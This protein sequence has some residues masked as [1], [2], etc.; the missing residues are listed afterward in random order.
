MPPTVE[1]SNIGL[2]IAIGAGALALLFAI[3]LA[4]RVMRVDEGNERV[5]EIGKAIQEG[6]SAFLSRE[7]RVLLIFVVIVTGVLLLLGFI[8]DEQDW[9]V[10]ISY[11][12]GAFGSGLT[13]LIG[14][15]VAVRAN[16]RTAAAATRALNPALRVAFSS[17][18]VM[19]ITVVGVGILG[20]VAL[21]LIFH[22]PD[23]VAGYSFG[24]SSIA[25]FARVGGGIYTKAADVGADL[26]GKVEAGIPEDDPRNA[27]V[28][29]DNVGDNVGDVA[30]MG[31]D[32]F[33]SYVGAIIATLALAGG[34]A[35]I[36]GT[37]VQG[38][39][40]VVLPFMIAAAGIVASIL[41]TFVVRTSE[42]AS[43]GSLLW[44]LRRG[45]FTSSIL[46]LGLSWLAI[47][48][49]FT[50]QNDIPMAEVWKV[51]GAV[52]VGLGA[53]VIIG[54]ATE[55]FT[56]YEYRPTKGIAAR[57]ETGPATVIISGFA[58]GMLSTVIPDTHHRRG[59]HRRAPTRRALR[60]R[61]RRRGH[62]LHPGHHPSHRRL[63]AGSRQR[64]RYRGAG[65]PALGGPRTH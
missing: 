8:R 14:M 36:G 4:M 16:M 52:A 63:R 7:Y 45:V 13:G 41:G 30:G 38:A 5:R 39:P 9:R 37:D 18:G 55:Y 40:G 3:F 28:I 43:I 31:A 24:A 26:A 59:G 47:W 27:A 46:V 48:W 17:G 54:L 10:A 6:A 50:V 42:K 22:D 65:P 56:S 15:N 32:L 11:I 25:L 1:E 61:H 23:I 33:E 20:A 21:W 51:F 57:T 58:T 35:F 49:L 44:S 53:G 34:A 29:A 64:R 60:H 62:A 19:G 2:Y 12:V